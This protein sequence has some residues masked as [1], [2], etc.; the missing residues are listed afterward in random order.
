[1]IGIKE[2]SKGF[3]LV[4]LI[5]VMAVFLLVTG[6]AIGIFISIVRQQK[7]ILSEQELLNQTSYVME[8][9]SKA[10]RMARKD[11]TGDCLVK[12]IDSYPGFV[13]LLTRPN[14]GTSFFEGIKFL[15][16]SDTDGSGLPACQEFYLDETGV[17]KEKKTYWPYS[18][19]GDDKAVALT[20]AKFNIEAV[21][22]GIN[23]YNGCYGRPECPQTAPEGE[24]DKVQP[25]VTILLDIRVDASQPLRK[26]Q[27]TVS[28][29]NL[30]AQ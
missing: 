2:K 26:F 3:T 5:V 28:Q 18:P 20:S 10:M 15:N 1:M 22:F 17:L 6:T 8:Y 13:Y 24:N 12:D 7:R 30:N 25:R 16:Q 27:T 29:R 21:R 23:G 14:T 9:M 11:E 4:E 19:I